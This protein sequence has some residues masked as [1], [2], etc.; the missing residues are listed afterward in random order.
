MFTHLL[1]HY[2]TAT[3]IL[4]RAP[5]IYNIITIVARQD[6]FVHRL[7]NNLRRVPLPQV[8][9]L[10]GP[11]EASL[12]L[13]RVRLLP[14]RRARTVP[15]LRPLL[16]VHLRLRVRL[17]LLHD[18]QVQ[19]QLPGVQGGH[20]LL[21]EEPPGPAVRSRHTRALLPQPGRVRLPLPDMQEDRGEQGVHERGVDGEGE[22]HP[23]AA[24]AGGPGKGGGH[25]V[26]RLREE[27]RGQGLALP[28][29]AVSLV[30]QLQHRGGGADVVGRMR[31]VG[32]V[33][34][35]GGI[36]RASDKYEPHMKM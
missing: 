11:Q 7:R 31:Q 3:L 36:E 12:P 8:Q 27:E 34:G 22:G 18:G 25:R 19:E 15:P 23:D 30:F 29:G 33:E 5:N 26:Q 13:R 2:F 16:H 32:D 21:P 17:P 28:G 9:H 35:A 20:V 4:T 24:H 6:E 1:A 14:R 10:D